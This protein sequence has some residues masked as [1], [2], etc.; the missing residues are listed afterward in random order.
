MRLDTQFPIIHRRRALALA[1]VSALILPAVVHAAGEPAPSVSLAWNANPEPDVAGYK[2]HFGAQSGVYTNVID[3]RGATSTSLPQ[4]LM[5]S[6]YYM[7]VSAYNSAGQEG[8]R[9]AEFAL[10][11]AV[12]SSPALST[13]FAFGGTTEGQGQLQWK[14]PKS[15]AGT[16]S[17]FKVYASEDLKTWT[18]TAQ[19]DPA[20]PASSDSEWLYFNYPYQATKSRMFFRV[21]AGNAFGSAE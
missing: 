6:T 15:A 19:I 2:V 5:G 10:A 9:S 16:A 4:L 21:A 8:P 13:T 20:K 1:L 3:V 12:P 18:E 17:D 7:A 11:A 14:Y